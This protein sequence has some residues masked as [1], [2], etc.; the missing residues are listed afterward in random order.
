ME[1]LFEYMDRQIAG[2]T[3]DFHRY[4]YPRIKWENRMLGLVGPRGVGKTTLFLQR[5][6]EAHGRG[7]SIRGGRASSR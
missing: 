1:R 4:L 3:S 2:V 5:I 7:T 6:K